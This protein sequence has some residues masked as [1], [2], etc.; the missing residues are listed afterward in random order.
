M[1]DLDQKRLEQEIEES[2]AVIR[3]NKTKSDHLTTKIQNLATK[4]SALEI[5]NGILQRKV[6]WLRDCIVIA[7]GIPP[8]HVKLHETIIGLKKELSRD[9]ILVSRQKEL[10]IQIAEHISRLQH[11]CDHPFVIGYVGYEG[12]YATDCSD[13]YCGYRRC[14]VCELSECS[15]ST[16]SENFKILLENEFRI[17][18]TSSG[19]RNERME[20]HK[21]NIWQPLEPI[22]KEVFL[23]RKIHEF[24]NRICSPQKPR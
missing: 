4:K 12:S 3:D 22:V 24:F 16:R 11:N 2:L 6:G 20:F 18:Q 17:I 10:A 15:Q 13:A 1:L 14:L 5:R 7:N 19:S 8:L 21:F 23:E 9:D